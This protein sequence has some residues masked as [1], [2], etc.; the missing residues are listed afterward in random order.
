MYIKSRHENK[1]P[2]M[3]IENKQESDRS[4]VPDVCYSDSVY[5]SINLL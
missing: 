4:L 1:L 3:L 2:H 5:H